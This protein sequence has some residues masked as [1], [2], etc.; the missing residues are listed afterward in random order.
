MRFRPV[1]LFSDIVKWYYYKH[2]D[3]VQKESEMKKCHVAEMKSKEC[4]GDEMLRFAKESELAKLTSMSKRA[5]DSDIDYGS[6]GGGPTGYDS[7]EWHSERYE[8]NNLYALVIGDMLVGGAVLQKQEKRLFIHRIFID[9]T[10][11]RKGY[12]LILMREIE[13]LFEDVEVFFLD[14][15]QWNIRTNSF[16]QKCGYVEVGKEATPWF[17]LILYEKRRLA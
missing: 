15:P 16:Y 4:A 2:N 12:G 3:K 10:H 6:K 7:V 13:A 14:T 1:L 17:D 5:F 8:E 11:F 9:P